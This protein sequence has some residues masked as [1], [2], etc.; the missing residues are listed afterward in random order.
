MSDLRSPQEASENEFALENSQPPTSSPG[1][2]SSPT[3]APISCDGLNASLPSLPRTIDL[4]PRA[5]KELQKLAKSELEALHEREKDHAIKV[6]QSVALRVSV[7]G[8]GCSG[9]SYCMHFIKYVG[10][11]NDFVENFEDLI[12]VVD[13]KSALYLRGTTID[14]TEGLD[15][16]GF[17]FD[18]P[19]TTGQCGCGSSFSV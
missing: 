5:L 12:V 1:S 15:G 6:I 8:G 4:T 19:N 9:F 18:N 16:R 3:S 10:K 11:E 17:V 14:Y 2:E 7:Q 13:N